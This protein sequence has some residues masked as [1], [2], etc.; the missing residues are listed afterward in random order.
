LAPVRQNVASAKRKALADDEIGP[1][2]KEDF[3]GGH[4]LNPVQARISCGRDT[5]SCQQ[6]LVSFD[7]PALTRQE[8]PMLNEANSLAEDIDREGEQD[9]SFFGDLH[10]VEP[11]V[12]HCRHNAEPSDQIAI[13]LN[14]PAAIGEE[15]AG[16]DLIGGFES[17]GGS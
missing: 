6:V 15:V 12:R 11:Q 10:G 4:G 9:L 17:I 8:V 7:D 5:E 14:Y 3:A 13:L 1:N 2:G 16:A